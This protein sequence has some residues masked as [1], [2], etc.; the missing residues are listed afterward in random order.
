MDVIVYKPPKNKYSQYR[1]SDFDLLTYAQTW[2]SQRD[3]LLKYDM[4]QAKLILD[5]FSEN[6]MKTHIDSGRS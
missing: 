6:P 4:R 1:K 3:Y 2:G 5:K